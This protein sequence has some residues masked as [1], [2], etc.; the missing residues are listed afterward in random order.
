M[1][2]TRS[3]KCARNLVAV[4]RATIAIQTHSAAEALDAAGVSERIEMETLRCA[5]VALFANH[6]IL[7]LAGAIAMDVVGAV[8]VARGVGY[9]A[10]N[11]SRNQGVTLVTTGAVLAPSTGVTLIASANYI[12]IG[13][14]LAVIGKVIAAG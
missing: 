9:L 2:D 5:G 3:S 13:T 8:H 14:L 7:A 12:A 4:P 1:V 10:A 11:S 6:A